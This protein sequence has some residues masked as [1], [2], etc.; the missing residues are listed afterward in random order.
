MTDL[1]A[2]PRAPETVPVE[3]LTAAEAEEELARLAGLIAHH[4]QLY[5]Q[6]DQPALSDAAYDALVR[7]NVAIEARFPDRI[8]ADSPSRRLGASPAAGFGRVQHRVP[9]LSLSNAFSDADIETF[10]GR[11]RR[12]LALDP[13]APLMFLAEPKV[14]G[15]SCALLYQNGRLIRAATRGD[16]SE[17]E[18]VTANLR[19]L[20]PTEAPPLLL[21]PDAAGGRPPPAILEVRGEVYMDRRDFAALNAARAAAGEPPFANP[22]NAAAGSLRQL[23]P[24]VTSSRPLRFFAYAWGETSEPF[25]RTQEE[26]RGLLRQWGFQLNQPARLCAG[27]ADL[28][29]HYEALGNQRADL[30]FD[31][32]GLVCKVDRLDFQERLGVVSRSPRWAIAWKFPAEQAVTRLKAI[33]IQVGRTG[34]LTPVAELEPVTVGGVVVSRATLHNEDEIQRKD[35]RVGDRVIVQRAGDVIPQIVGVVLADRPADASPFVFPVHCPEC[36]SH[37]V[38]EAEAVVRRCAGGLICPAQARERL[39]H[40]VSRDAFDI[41]G[42]GE[43]NLAAFWDDGLVRAPADL[44]TLE[45]RD[46]T[47]LTPLRLR[48]GWGRR[49]A[50]N[51]FAAIARRRTIALER[52]IYALGIPQIGQ[53]TARLLARHYGSLARWLAAMTAAADPESPAWQ[54]LTGIDGIGAGMAGEIVEFFAEPRNQAAVA[55][56]CAQLLA[57]E[58]AIAPAAGDSPLAGKT[59]V[60][61]GALTRQTRAEAKARAEALGAKVAGSVSTRTDYLI[62]GADAG[63]KIAKARAA[64]VAILSE[65]QWLN[66]SGQALRAEDSE[67]N[68]KTSGTPKH[69]E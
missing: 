33:A 40:F 24:A 59:V 4:D 51:L 34:A 13:D 23:D 27:L 41:E 68:M 37:A 30:P 61:T 66:L 57:V 46:R 1:F 22:R 19:T 48:E 55:A 63:S 49:S 42:L 31:I 56:L 18:D 15:L 35:V 44:F 11:I 3:A 69:S 38:R 58:D 60:F 53:V 47:C 9:M 6:Q 8:R 50:E 65:E 45:A 16:G 10:I 21:G 62:A 25:A 20:A 12:F 43:K 54:D 36:G 2:A 26:A 29:Q 67:E 17:G 39:R 32:D 7:R 52:F 5:F 14:D 28:R 64:G